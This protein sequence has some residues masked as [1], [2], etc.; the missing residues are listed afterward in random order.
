MC[1]CLDLD[2]SQHVSI[3]HP[4]CNSYRNCRTQHM[5]F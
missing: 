4:A 1:V 3:F 2:G 5:A